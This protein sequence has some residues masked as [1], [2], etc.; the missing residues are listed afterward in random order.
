M[1]VLYSHLKQFE[2]P[3]LQFEI[4][5]NVWGWQSEMLVSPSLKV[6]H[7]PFITPNIILWYVFYMQLQQA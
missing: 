4:S 2:I 3:V 7:L 1:N 5:Q 6:S